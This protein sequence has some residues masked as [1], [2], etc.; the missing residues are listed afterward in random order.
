MELNETQTRIIQ[1]I[2]DAS[3]VILNLSHQIHANPELGYEERF[4]SGLLCETLERYGFR[5]ERGYADIPTAFC[6]RK[7]CRA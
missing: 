5:V 1:E 4:A 3:E 7:G 2:E 6:A